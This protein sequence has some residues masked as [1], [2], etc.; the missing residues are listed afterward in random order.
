MIS[1]FNNN[2]GIFTFI[3]SIIALISLVIAYLQYRKHSNVMKIKNSP[4][5]KAG[6]HI[7][8]GGDIVINNQSPLEEAHE[9]Y[10][11]KQNWTA[12]MREI[13][14]AAQEN[15]SIYH[16]KVDQLA[17][18]FIRVGSKNF[19]EG[20]DSTYAAKYVDALDELVKAGF[21][22]HISGS[23]YRLKNN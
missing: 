12:E 11:D 18:G 17:D 1:L 20:R 4:F 21:I 23:L 10:S 14:Q 9:K 8:A 7:T 5:I 6:G 22:K 19:C 13:F 16:F 15:D 3:G 2:S